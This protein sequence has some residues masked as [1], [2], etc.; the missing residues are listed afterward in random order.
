MI[1]IKVISTNGTKSEMEKVRQMK[2][3]L[4]ELYETEINMDK[5]VSFIE[6]VQAYENGKTIYSQ[7]S[8]LIETYTYELKGSPWNGLE[9]NSGL[10]ISSRE[11]LTYKWYIKETE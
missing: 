3:E 10:P 7:S 1:K 9:D 11:I 4:N 8:N 6:A 5:E 2:K